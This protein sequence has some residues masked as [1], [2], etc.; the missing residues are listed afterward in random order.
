MTEGAT[1]AAISVTDLRMRYGSNEAAHGIRALRGCFRPRPTSS[2]V[3]ASARGEGWKPAK[4]R[5]GRPGL[6]GDMATVTVDSPQRPL[7]RLT[8]WAE[9]RGVVL[10]GLEAVHPKLEDIFF[11]L[12]ADDSGAAGGTRERRRP[13]PSPDPLRAHAHEPQPAGGRVRAVSGR[14]YRTWGGS[15]PQRGAA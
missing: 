14:L 12:T 9:E 11:E 5:V 4:M 3:S 6:S 7:Y 13:R 1:G 10:D 2:T 8:G 15:S